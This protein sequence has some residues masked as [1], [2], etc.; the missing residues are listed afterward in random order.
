MGGGKGDSKTESTIRYAPYLEALHQAFLAEISAAVTAAAGNSPYAAYTDLDFEA[1]FYGA[2]FVM[3]SFPSLYDMFGKFMAGLD[4]EVLYDETYEDLI[5]GAV[6]QNM[7]SQEADILSD[8]IE[9]EALPRFEAGMRDINA[10]MS[11][12]F[13]IGRAM[14]EVG[15]TKALSRFSADLRG[16]LLP[17]I[18]DRWKAHLD[19]NKEVINVYAQIMKFAIIQ[20]MDIDNHNLEQHSKDVLW[21]FNAYQYETNALA[22]MSAATNTTSSA[23]GASTAQKA[24]GGAMTGAATGGFLGGAIAGSAGGP[25]G[26]AIGGVIGLVGG[27]L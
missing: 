26:A 25:I 12:T 2:G 24:I 14:L 1:G 22:A 6:T 21:P 5:N 3:S 18:A 19:W 4:V 11:S 8:D 16:K 17:I 27:L 10:V 9:N 20:K 13:V 15:R 7:I 23:A